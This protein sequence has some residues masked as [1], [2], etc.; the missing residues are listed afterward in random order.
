MKNMSY[1]VYQQKEK[2][3]K[4]V[5]CYRQAFHAGYKRQIFDDFGLLSSSHDH[6]LAG[7]LFA[8]DK[9]NICSDIQKIEY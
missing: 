6:T 2:R 7:F 9:S 5:W 4:K 3:E 1:S 8:Q